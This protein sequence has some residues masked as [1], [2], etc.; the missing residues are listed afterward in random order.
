MMSCRR[1]LFVEQDYG[2][3]LIVW[4]SGIKPI[5]CILVRIVIFFAKST[6]LVSF[7]NPSLYRILHGLRLLFLKN[8]LCLKYFSQ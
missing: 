3:V 7:I 5:V 2:R 6:F 4:F 1:V 8:H